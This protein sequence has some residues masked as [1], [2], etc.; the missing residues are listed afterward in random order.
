MESVWLPGFLQQTVYY[1]HAL[2]YNYHN[3][4]KWRLLKNNVDVNEVLSETPS[5]IDLLVAGE[6]STTLDR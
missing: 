3:S 4:N 1:G 6:L 5:G 2:E